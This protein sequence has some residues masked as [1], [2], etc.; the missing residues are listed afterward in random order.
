MREGERERERDTHTHTQSSFPACTKMHQSLETVEAG[1][2]TEEP[3][4]LQ[5][6]VALNAHCGLQGYLTWM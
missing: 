4:S 3:S 6:P 5:S 2:L 1:C